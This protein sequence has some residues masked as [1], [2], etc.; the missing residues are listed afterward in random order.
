[1]ILTRSTK[2]E[3]ETATT[4]KID[5]Q[6]FEIKATSQKKMSESLIFFAFVIIICMWRIAKLLKTKELYLFTLL[7]ALTG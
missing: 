3:A 2:R 7:K 4:E 1:M 5:E 6:N